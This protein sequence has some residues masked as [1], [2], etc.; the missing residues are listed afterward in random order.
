M[1]P[2]HVEKDRLY[3]AKELLETDEALLW[4]GHGF[5]PLDNDDTRVKETRELM[6]RHYPHVPYGM[7]VGNRMPDGA[8]TPIGLN[9]DGYY[10]VDV[11]WWPEE[12][13]RLNIHTLP[14]IQ[15]PVGTKLDPARRDWDVSWPLW[16]SEWD[17]EAREK[18]RP[19]LHKE[20]N[21]AGS[22]FRILIRPERTIEPFGDVDFS[23]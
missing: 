11:S 20:K 10:E 21:G 9:S 13:Y 12:V 6:E 22:G 8:K 17:E 14:G 15:S 3:F 16:W 23:L 5:D 18:A 19:F 1:I 2:I 4:V 7:S